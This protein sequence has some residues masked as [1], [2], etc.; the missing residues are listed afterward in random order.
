MVPDV[1]LNTGLAFIF[2]SA[3]TILA[4]RINF[5]SI[6][7][8]IFLGMMVGPHG[9]DLEIFS[10]KI[11]S[12]TESLELLSRLGV[13]LMLFYL[14][15]EFSAGKL[16]QSGKSL[17]KSGMAY[18]ALNFARGLGFGWIFFDS[19][20]EAMVV[21]GITGVS[22]SAIITKLLVD[23]KRTAN[24][25]TE[26]ILGIMVFEDVFIAAYLSVLSGIM[27]VGS[28]N[29]L[30]T[31][32][33]VLLIFALIISTITFGRHMGRVLEERLKFR[34]AET[35]VVAIFTMLLMAG[36]FTERLHVAEAIGALLLGLVL[37]ETTHNNRI[38]QMIIPLRD[39]FGAMFFFSFGMAIN[40]RSFSEVA[41]VAAA[42]V[43]MTILGNIAAGYIASGLSGYKKR[44]AAN[45][46]FTIMARGEFSIII[47]SFA[48]S[49]GLDANLS[50]FAAL[51]VVTLAFISP[52]LAKNTKFFHDT[53]EKAGNYLKL[54]GG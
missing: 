7:F 48:V 19:W 34:N 39:L 25:E 47:A 30:N 18:V 2:I 6:P 49:G 1:V 12:D 27:A 44:R 17:F 4:A 38:I 8:L 50:A 43:I 15:L 13:L 33:N 9:P 26:L 24:P 23:L 51:Y 3:A 5:S 52:F 45:V 14:G 32:V 16:A 35:F 46:A 11:I 42:A 53:F 21:A 36:V 22:S 10:L 20:A 41:L 54:P 37:A 29:I 31:V 28:L 40:C